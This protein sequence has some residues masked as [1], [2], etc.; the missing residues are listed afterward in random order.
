[1]EEERLEARPRGLVLHQNHPNP[2]NG[3]TV[4]RFEL[5]QGGEV[6]LAVY[7]LSGQQVAALAAGPREAGS[8][9]VRWDGRDAQGRSL[10]SGV[11]LCQLRG[12]GRAQVRKLLL[13]R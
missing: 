9:A 3:E 6:E 13:L 1:V 4:L 10:A 12:G 7:N 11:Y 8:H 2:F 5:P